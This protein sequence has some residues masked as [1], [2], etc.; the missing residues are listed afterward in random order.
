MKL[1]CK[2]EEGQPK[3]MGCFAKTLVGIGIYFL[4]C[5]L[6]GWMFGNSFSTPK[7]VLEE[8]TIYRIDLAGELVEQAAEENPMDAIM[9]EMSGQDITAQVGLNDLLSNIALAKNNDKVLGIYLR[10]GELLAAPASAKAL[11]DALVDFKESG[12]F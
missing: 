5:G 7:T 10:G 12:K 1:F 2:K 3:K 9:A 11:R 4:I 6:F 8:N